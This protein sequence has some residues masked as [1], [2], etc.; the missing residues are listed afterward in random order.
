MN[1]SQ[2]PEFEKDFRRLAK[3]YRSLVQ[4]LEEFRRVVAVR[5]YGNT[6]HFHVIAQTDAVRIVKARFFCRYLKGSSLRI[7]YAYFESTA[8]VE[9]IEIYFKGE[10]ENE[11]RRRIADYLATH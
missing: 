5:P 9:F 4:D 11:D 3:K 10:K 6:K 2:L 7:V 1:F 8:S